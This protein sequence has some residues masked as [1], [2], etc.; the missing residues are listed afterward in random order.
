MLEGGLLELRML[1]PPASVTWAGRQPDQP[2]DVTL[3]HSMC[4][5]EDEVCYKHN[6]HV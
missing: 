4:D 2:A 5:I 6:L 1:F 3:S